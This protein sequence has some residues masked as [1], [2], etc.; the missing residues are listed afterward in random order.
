MYDAH[1]DLRNRTREFARRVARAFRTLPTRDPVSRIW[2]E[3]MLR[4]AGSVGANYREAQRARSGAEYRSKIG[5]SLREA[6]ET[7]YW[8][9]LLELEDFFNEARVHDLKDEADQLIAIFVTLI[10][11]GDRR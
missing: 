1:G 3:Q 11:K 7:L 2:G 5:D 9:E 6:D 4:A 10:R 8:L